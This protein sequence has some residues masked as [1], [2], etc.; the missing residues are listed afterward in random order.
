MSNNVLCPQPMD[1]QFVQ[2]IRPIDG[3]DFAV[4]LLDNNSAIIG[5]AVQKLMF[6][7]SLSAQVDKTSSLLCYVFRNEY[8]RLFDSEL[9][10]GFHNFGFEL[11]NHLTGVLSI[12]DICFC[13]NSVCPV[14]IA[15]REQQVH[16][17]E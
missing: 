5:R 17:V 14:D 3:F 1:L 11:D 6:S 9:F 13:P 4:R 16:A 10:P 7:N 2:V 12:Y 8:I 15:Q